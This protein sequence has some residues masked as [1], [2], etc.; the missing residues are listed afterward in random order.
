M[1]WLLKGF[2]AL[3]A[4]FMFG[5]GLWPLSLVIFVYLVFS[6]RP[7]RQK[8]ERTIVVIPPGVAAEGAQAWKGGRR[9]RLGFE[10]QWRYLLGGLFLLAALIS[11]GERGTFSPLVFGGLGMLCFLWTPLSRS[12]HAPAVGYAPVRESTL[13]RSVLVPF[14]WMTVLEL[15][16]SSQESA[17][18]LS[19]L[20]DDLVVV[21]PPS[22]KPAAYLIVKQAAVGYHG[23]EARMSEKLRKLAGLLAHRG[24]YLMPLDSLEA[25]RRFP[26]SLQPIK[27]DL[28]RDSVLEAVGHYPYDVLAVK[29]DG[30]HAKSLG[31]YRASRSATEVD[32][33]GL[34][35]GHK[36]PTSGAEAGSGARNATLPSAR[37]SFERPPLLWEVVSCLQERFHFSDPDGYTMF[38]NNM[39][40]SRNVP[41]GQ[42][43]NLLNGGAAVTVESLSGAP[44]EMSRAQLRTIV[45]IYG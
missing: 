41:I 12:G 43:L 3:V 25:A 15:K 13:L 33:E 39:H 26:P 23:A 29:P 30:V 18:A 11:V 37:Q 31:A 44:V 42:K 19:V 9:G 28:G 10:W 35:A 16:L 27:M 22:E 32:I 8:V 20:H 6:L 36:E 24:A 40:L 21:A 34:I 5:A 17:R 38:L 1:G 14:Q 2:L 4:L 45:K 7:R